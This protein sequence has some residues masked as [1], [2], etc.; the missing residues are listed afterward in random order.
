MSK[1]EPDDQAL[2]SF[3]EILHVTSRVRGFEPKSV[4]DKEASEPLE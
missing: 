3:A 4:N 1:D 2:E